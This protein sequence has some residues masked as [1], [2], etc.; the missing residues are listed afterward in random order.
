MVY[1]T[2]VHMT[3]GTQHEHIESVKWLQPTDKST[4]QSTGAAMV[5][6]IRDQKGDARVTDGKTEVQIGVVEGTPPFIRTYADGVWT[7]NLLSLPRY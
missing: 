1:V 5:T 2:A 6:F 7:D 3:G 4:G